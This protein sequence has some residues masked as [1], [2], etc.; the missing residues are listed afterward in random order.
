MIRSTDESVYGGGSLN[1]S[2][3]ATYE[4]VAGG[5]PGTAT[6]TATGW[7]AGTTVR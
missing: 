1:T 5:S 7:P 2:R 3:G 4:A 6:L